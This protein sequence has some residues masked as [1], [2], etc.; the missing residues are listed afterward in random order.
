MTL[1]YLKNIKVRIMLEKEVLT[2]IK[3]YNMINKGDKV[4]IGVSGGPDSITLL[5]VLNKFKEKLN[6]KIYVAH[7]NHSIRK[8]ADEETEYVREFCKKID[9]EFFFKKIDVES[10]AKKLKIGTEEAGRNIRYAFFEEVA[11]KVGANKIA[12]AHNSNDNAETVLMN[13]IRGTSI[14]GLKGIEKMRDNKFIR[15]LIE[16]TRATIE[17]YC[18]IEKLSPRYDKSN[19]ENI[20]TRNKIRNLLIPYI[21]KEFNP[22]IIEGINRLSN[23]AEEEECFINSMVEEEYKRIVI[24]KKNNNTKPNNTN[25]IV[26]KSKKQNANNIIEKIEKDVITTNIAKT[27]EEEI[28]AILNLKEFNELDNVIKSRLIL[29]T[30]SKLYGGAVGI[31]KIHIDDI[32]KLCENNIGNKYLTPRKGIKIYVKK[33]KIFF[34]SNSSFRRQ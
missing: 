19:K 22:N 10:E 5:N 34:L 14:S 21:Q 32:I 23:I 1:G 30:I 29:Y 31:E 9:V 4:V 25:Y 15:P 7:I 27:E 20:Y 13:I 12:T 17:E 3:K 2:T 26:Q 6:I 16:T 11:E 18:R 24:V 33:G 28:R 8:E